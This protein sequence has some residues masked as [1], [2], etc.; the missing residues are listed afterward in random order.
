M[1]I[2]IKATNIDLTPE[3]TDYVHAKMGD[4]EK[5]I[6]PN[7]PSS[8]QMY[9]ELEKTTDHHQTGDNLYRA[10]VNLHIDGRYVR[11]E[12]TEGHIHAAI[13][14]VKDEVSH[15]IKKDQDKERTFLRKGGAAL[16]RLFKGS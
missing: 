5:F 9:V 1:N 4:V 7:D 3:L 8:V 12:E 16:K 2:Q 11:A 15:I 6:T 14:S 10:E 13:D